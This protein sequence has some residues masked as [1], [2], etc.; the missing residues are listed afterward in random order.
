LARRTGRSPAKCLPERCRGDVKTFSSVRLGC[1]KNIIDSE[2]MEALLEERGWVLQSSSDFVDAILVNTCAFIDEAK[3]EAVDAILHAV[4]M[5]KQGRCGRVIVAGCLV[6]RYGPELV[7]ELP[8]VDLFVGT[9]EV[10]RIAR[11]VASLE[12]EAGNAPRLAAE[13]P[14][15]LMTA[16]HSRNM[17]AIGPSA[18]IKIAE[19]CSN[20]CSYCVIPALRGP[21]RSR[22]VEDILEEAEGLARNGVL[23]LVLVAQ[24]T[25]CYGPDLPG[26]PGLA[27]LL[28]ELASIEKIRWIRVLYTHPRRLDKGLFSVMAREKKVCPYLDV[29]LQHI[30]DDIL[31]AMNRRCD[32]RRIRRVLEQAREIIPDVALRT[33]LIVGFPGESR[34]RF[35]KLLDFVREIRFDHL[36]VFRYS[37]EE[38]TA[39]ASM[40]KQVGTRTAE[41]RRNIIMSEQ[42]RISGEINQARRGSVYDVLLEEPS[43]IPGYTHIGRTPF[44]APEIDGVTYVDA[45][46]ASTGTI[47]RCVITDADTYDLFGSALSPEEQGTGISE[48]AKRHD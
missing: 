26:R 24:E 40:E 2:V 5:K 30:D 3:E 18:Y 23:E 13:P 36:G 8:E 12:N 45:P 28:E 20:H 43:D 29:P 1:P 41:S 32:S 37:R 34:D 35:Q 6:Q 14:R 33:S 27:R 31:R 21:F 25:T 48:T 44:Q 9:D 19:G 10:G 11:H 7:R 46:G 47:I 16:N 15:F 39:A 22:P 38:G 42:A 17:V 4:E